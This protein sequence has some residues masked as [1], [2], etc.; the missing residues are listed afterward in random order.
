MTQQL[1][2]HKLK[3]SRTHNNITPHRKSANNKSLQKKLNERMYS[4]TL[5]DTG[6]ELNEYTTHVE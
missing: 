3:T 5:V 4:L 2:S 6:S 1:A